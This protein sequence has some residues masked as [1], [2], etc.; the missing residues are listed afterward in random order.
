MKKII[1]QNIA[2]L[3]LLFFTSCVNNTLEVKDSETLTDRDGNHYKTVVIGNQTWM[4]ENLKVSTYKNGDSIKYCSS[5]KTWLDSTGSYGYFMNRKTT[6]GDSVYGKIYNGYAIYDSRGIAPEGWHVAT[7]ED[8]TELETYLQS[9]V[10]NDKE[11]VNPSSIAKLLADNKEHFVNINGKTIDA[12]WQKIQSTNDS[13][14]GTA[15]STNNI[16]KFSAIPGGR[17]LAISKSFS[18][19]SSIDKDSIIGAFFWSPDTK[20]SSYTYRALYTNCKGIARVI[21]YIPQNGYYV[22]C[23]KNK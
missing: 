21:S 7:D 20:N 6:Y 8:W 5:P 23:V 2:L 4:A 12:S 18:K 14:P 13:T 15:L 1:Y 9:S 19:F 10:N 22:R 17:R 16:T 3:L 11:N